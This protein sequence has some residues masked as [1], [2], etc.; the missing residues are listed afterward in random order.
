MRELRVVGL[1]PLGL[2]LETPDID[3]VQRSKSA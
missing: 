2:S 1:R 3:V